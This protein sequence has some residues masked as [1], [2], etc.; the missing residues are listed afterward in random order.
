MQKGS[1]EKPA[2]F[3]GV[4]NIYKK[5]AKTPLQAMERFVMQHPEYK[6]TTLTYAGRLDPMAEGVLVILC[7][8]K[9]KERGAYTSLDKDYEFEF[10]LGVE[11][12]TFDILG[13]IVRATGKGEG[14]SVSEKDVAA[15]LK[16]Y[17]GRF[18]QKY[19]P[20]SSKTVD[21]VPLHELARS[22]TLVESNLPTHQV[23]AKSIELLG[24]SA[25]SKEEL[26]KHIFESIKWLEGD[27][28]QEEILAKWAEYL[29]S[30]ESPSGFIAFKARISCGSGFYVRQLV[31][32]I[33]RDLGVGAVTIS[34][35]R[36]RVGPYTLAESQK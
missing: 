25:M 2:G 8:E 18:E 21:G 9:N 4:L 30:P 28:R 29:D 32:D 3:D 7:G 16:K 13:K 24:S 34:I 22:G 5:K 12:D 35:L 23:E 36:T 17:V 1:K 14:K 31:A 19:P 33:G 20:F 15:A 26:R 10:I 11:T 27:F 6:G